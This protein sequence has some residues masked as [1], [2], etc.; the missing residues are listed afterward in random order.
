MLRFLSTSIC[1]TAMHV[2]ISRKNTRSFR[3][4]RSVRSLSATSTSTHVRYFVGCC[5]NNV[6]QE[7]ID[8]EQSPRP[9]RQES[10]KEL[11]TLISAVTRYIAGTR[12]NIRISQVSRTDQSEGRIEN[13]AMI[14]IEQSALNHSMPTILRDKPNLAVIG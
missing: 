6:E 11:R 4:T 9:D 7:V 1:N 12:T 10:K 13:Q 8:D 2:C 3:E 5:T 14:L